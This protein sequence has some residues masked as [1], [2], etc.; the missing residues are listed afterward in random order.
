MGIVHGFLQAAAATAI[1]I[2]YSR[3]A[4][5]TVIRSFVGG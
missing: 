5:F 2:F 3:N 4:V 1:L